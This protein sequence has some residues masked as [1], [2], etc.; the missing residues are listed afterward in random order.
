MGILD[1]FEQRVD[2]LV[3]GAFAK[4]FE[5]E[6][7]PVE[8]AAALQT[9]TTDRA[10]IIGSGRTV[11]PNQ[12][13][14]DLAPVDFQ[15]LNEF[16]A[17][18][19]SELAASVREHIA[20]QRYTA[21]GQV[22]VAFELDESLTTGLFRVTG[23]V[24]DDGGQDDDIAVAA[25]TRGPH[26]VIDGFSHSITRQH[27]VLGRGAEADIRVDDPS[28]SRK[29]CEI[30][31]SSPIRLV[32]L[33]STNGTWVRGERVSSFDLTEDVDLT[34]GAVTIQFRLR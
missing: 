17:A 5:A 27:T 10:V 26:V 19:C 24:R 34:L 22:S 7:Q 28:V 1:R 12:F 20:E 31:L 18:L 11:V 25:N 21:L 16:G 23:E 30:V 8:L 32:D 2:R 4:A 6:V 3:N 15:R 9:E 13:T 14:I 29:H 33:G